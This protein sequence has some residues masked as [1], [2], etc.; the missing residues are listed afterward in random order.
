MSMYVL[1]V[2]PGTDLHVAVQLRK[3][4]H[5]VRCPQRTM[6]IRKDGAWNSRTEPIFPGYLFVE[7]EIDRKRYD[8]ICQTDGVVGFLRSSGGAIGKLKPHEE[9]YIQWLWNYGKPITASRIYTTFHGDKMVLSGVLRNY[10]NQVVKLDLRQRRARVRVPI[11]G[12][13]YTI[14]LPVIGI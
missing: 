8:N 12:H 10:W 1:Q 14:T 7:E 4:G 2:K 11:C 13:E 9:A 5:L 6:D 3:K